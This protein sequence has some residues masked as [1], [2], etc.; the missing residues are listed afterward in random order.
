VVN[1]Q[2]NADPFAIADA[3]AW[4]LRTSGR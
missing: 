2:T 1:V 3:V 4:T